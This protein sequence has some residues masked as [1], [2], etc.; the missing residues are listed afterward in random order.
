MKDRSTMGPIEYV[1]ESVFW[2]LIS[3]TWYKNIIFRCIPNVTYTAS[4]TALW[5]LLFA[6]IAA[7]AVCVFRIKRTGWSV[8][9]SLVLPYGIYTVVTYWKHFKAEY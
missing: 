1:F 8:L 9:V 4:K 7:C 3:M 5:I 6:S 2:C